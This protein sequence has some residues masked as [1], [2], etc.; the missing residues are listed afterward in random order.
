MIDFRYHLVSLV[1]VFLALAL[2]IVLGAGPLA[3][4]IGETLTGQVGKLR[5]DRNALSEQLALTKAIL[6]TSDRVSEEYAPRIFNSV[7]QD[8]PVALVT[9]PGADGEDIKNTETKISQAGGS[10]S[11]QINLREDFFSSTKAAYR[12]ALSGQ[13]VQYLE[14]KT[15]ATTPDA[16]LACAVGQLLF[17]GNNDALTGILTV[18]D[19]PLIQVALPG[20]TPARVAVVVAPRT[21]KNLPESRNTALASPSPDA[22]AY[23]EFVST[24]GSFG[25]GTVVY[26]SAV[27]SSDLLTQLRLSGKPI[28]TLDGIGTQASLLSLP[29]ALLSTMNGNQGAWGSGEGATALVP[30]VDTLPKNQNPS[31]NSSAQPSS[32]K[33]KPKS[34]GSNASKTKPPKSSA[35]KS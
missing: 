34:P 10:V 3:Q 17:S 13:L 8:V 30:P 31:A 11:S 33:E 23:L 28:S 1:A 35:P 9:L 19:T 24:L 2:G 12:E 27:A 16:I 7:L 6:S 20:H 25:S 15:R 32:S 29:F 18:A 21:A 14:D 5:E 4:P 22:S 26:G